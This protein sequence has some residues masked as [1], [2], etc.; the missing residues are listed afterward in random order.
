[1]VCGGVLL[2]GYMWWEMAGAFIFKR[3]TFHPFNEKLVIKKVV[4]N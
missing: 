1:M 4:N 2:F 3:D